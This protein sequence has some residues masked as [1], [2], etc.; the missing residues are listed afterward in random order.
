[1]PS[2]AARVSEVVEHLVRRVAV[3][4][5]RADVRILERR[6]VADD[7]VDECRVSAEDHVDDLL[8]VDAHRERLLDL[9][10]EKLSI[11]RFPRIRVPGD[12]R[13]L[14]AGNLVQNDVVVLLEDVDR[15]ERHLVD[16]VD[17]P[18]L[19]VGD[20]GVRVRVVRER[21]GLGI[22]RRA[23]VV[24][25]GDED[26]RSLLLPLLHR[27]RPARDHRQV[28]L[29]VVRPE[30]FPIGSS[31]RLPDVARKNPE[32]LELVE[33]VAHG[34]LVVEHDGR[35]VDGVRARHVG[36]RS[37]HSGRR[38]VLVLDGRVDRPGSVV[39]GHR[40]AVGPLRARL[41]V[42]GPV[43]PVGRS[44][45]GVG[46]VADDLEA[47]VRVVVL[48]ELGEDHDHGI[49][50]LRLDPVERVQRVD[51]A[52][53]SDPEDPARLDG[54]P[55]RFGRLRVTRRSTRGSR[56]VRRCLPARVSSATAPGGR[57]RDDK[58]HRPRQK[59]P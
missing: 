57:D 8:T 29:G 36:E 45:P 6:D 54:S 49:S 35:V 48:H 19:Q 52:D 37:R 59:H 58:S 50:G 41:Q 46:P 42:E 53:R 24:R 11:H 21:D 12:V 30:P 15:V 33:H 1:M 10:V 5:E 55:A 17:V 47:L 22:R 28:L 18:V 9:G 13:G 2:D 38:P 14:G 34:R 25:V 23:V 44:L 20:D 4:L 3:V 43:L 39:G 51:V 7:A 26:R 56:G 31:E 16:P 40:R 27:V 32:L